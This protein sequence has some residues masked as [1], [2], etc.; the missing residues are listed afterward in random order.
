M[1]TERQVVAILGVI[2]ATATLGFA[3]YNI[4]KAFNPNQTVKV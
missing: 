2:A 1:V 4:Y 3:I